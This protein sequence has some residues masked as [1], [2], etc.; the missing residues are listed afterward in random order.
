MVRCAE[1]YEQ[2]TTKK[3]R[4]KHVRSVH[5]LSLEAYTLKWKY[6]GTNP[7]C[8][9]GCGIQTRWVSQRSDFRTHVLRHGISGRPRST[10]T[11]RKI[12]EKNTV[13]MKR[14]HAKNPELS[15]ES[16]VKLRSGLTPE[17][18]ER[19]IQATKNAYQAMTPE[20]K[21]GFSDHSKDLWA[22]GILRDAKPKAVAT[23]KQRSAN[24]EY[25]FETRNKR[26]SESITRVYQAGGPQWSQG[27]YTSTKTGRS[28]NFRS[29]W[30]E[31]Y[32]KILDDD[33]DVLTWDYESIVIPYLLDGKTHNYIPDFLLTLVD[34]S[35]VLVEVKPSGLRG[36]A[37]NTAKREAALKMC[38]VNRW[39][40]LEWSPEKIDTDQYGKHS[41]KSCEAK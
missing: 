17:V 36:N 12:G 40:Y 19:R 34:G 39:T 26:L 4:A 25:D 30:E 37:A 38:A 9:C 6:A 11:K 18:N 33:L 23:F 35:K 41:L 10:E 14:W 2:F 7:T 22:K 20:R 1:C 13:N 28:C 27:T 32:M 24:G 5:G 21:Q 31:T 3:R 15:A 29:S 16:V 8:Q